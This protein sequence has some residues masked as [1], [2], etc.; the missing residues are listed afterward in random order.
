[1]LTLA[2]ADPARGFEEYAE[3]YLKTDGQL[4]YSDTHQLSEYLGEYHAEVDQRTGARHPGSEMITELYVPPMRLPEFLRSAA[5]WLVE[6]K[7]QVIYGTIR[8]IQPDS[9]T[10]MAWAR[11]RSACIIFNLHVDHVDAEIEHA[12]EALRGLIDLAIS[13]GGSYYL[14]YHR[15]A[16][17]TQ[18]EACY[19]RVREFFARKRFYDPRGLFQSDWYNHYAPHFG[20]AY[21]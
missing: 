6:R 13:L 10:V 4:Y 20:G 5:K 3:H 7:A 8:L 17:P 9:E 12:A 19:P 18:L 1:L 11:A 2:H 14:T 21:G 16:T 15:Y